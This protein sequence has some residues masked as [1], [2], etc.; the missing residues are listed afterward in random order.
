VSFANP[1]EYFLC[2]TKNVGVRKAHPNLPKTETIQ[3]DIV[4]IVQWQNGTGGEMK[5]SLIK[6]VT[7]A[8]VG[9]AFAAG[10]A[11][12]IPN[13][14]SER[15]FPLDALGSE[16]F[17]ERRFVEFAERPILGFSERQFVE[18]AERPI[19]GSPEPQNG[20]QKKPVKSSKIKSASKKNKPLRYDPA[21][22]QLIFQDVTAETTYPGGSSVSFGAEATN[23]TL[24]S[25]AAP[26]PEPATMILVGTGLAGL[27][28]VA[29]RR[30]K[31][32]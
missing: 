6:G 16:G 5:P 15:T 30:A 20:K 7:L 10:N 21:D 26:I 2:E 27:A 14:D 13:V 19:L 3:C 1:N 17:S 25:T 24:N 23:L 22:F 29:R 11:M 9:L 4:L 32:A 28:G 8:F 12:A 31:K 18:F